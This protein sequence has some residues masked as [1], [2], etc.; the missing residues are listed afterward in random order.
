MLVADL[1]FVLGEAA[2]EDR[3]HAKHRQQVR[4]DAR[5]QQPLGLARAGEVEVGQVAIER[6]VLE[7]VIGR[8]PVAMVGAV[9]RHARIADVRGGAVDVHQAIRLTE[10]QRLQRDAVDDAEDRRDRADAE[11]DDG[12]GGGGEAGRLQQQPHA[13]REIAAELPQPRAGAP[14]TRGFANRIRI[15]D[16]D[17]RGAARL[18]RRHAAV[19]VGLDLAI[20]MKLQLFVQL[21]IERR[22]SEQAAQRDV[23]TMVPAHD[24]TPS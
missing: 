9:D 13:V 20:E 15:A 19:D 12:D 7:D 8:Q 4:R 24:V 16:G 22:R 1:V 21:A 17:R 23:E 14:V 6:D 3:R 10:R 11:R 18:C 5:G 2:A